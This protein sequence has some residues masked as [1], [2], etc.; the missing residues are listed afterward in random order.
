[1]FHINFDMIEILELNTLIFS[2]SLLLFNKLIRNLQ[3]YTFNKIEIFSRSIIIG[4][5]LLF[6]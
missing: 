5:T 4:V 2:L 1:M 3:L 6:S